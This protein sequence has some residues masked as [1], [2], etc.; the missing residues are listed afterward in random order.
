MIQL[1]SSNSAK[2]PPHV[3]IHF[4]PLKSI[5]I[6]RTLCFG[7]PEFDSLY[8]VQFVPSYFANPPYHVP[9]H[10]LPNTSIA[11][12]RISFDCNP[13]FAVL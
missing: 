11:I 8:T 13:E 6:E 12:A 9:I 3:P 4:V 5:A 10:L 7:K 1:E 2:P